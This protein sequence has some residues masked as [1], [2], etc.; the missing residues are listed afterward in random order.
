MWSNGPGD[1]YA[2]HSHSY[3]KVLYCVEGSIA[4]TVDGEQVEMHPGD[5][6]DLT[7]GTMHSATV[8][9]GGVMCLEAHR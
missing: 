2:S 6:L 3:H 5:R 1:I 8:G 4:F 7:A 9:P